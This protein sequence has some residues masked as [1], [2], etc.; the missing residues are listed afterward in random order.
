MGGKVG[1]KSHKI[2]AETC[3]IK[4]SSGQVVKGGTVL[5]REGDRWKPG[6]NVLGRMHLTA[7]CSG[8][9]YFTRKRNPKNGKV[10]TIVNVREAEK[11]A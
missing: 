4:V 6:I 2:Y 8:E 3:G 1:G 10:D 7:A 11:K 9:I 5:T